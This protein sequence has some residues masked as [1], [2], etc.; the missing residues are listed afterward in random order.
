[1]PL[2]QRHFLVFALDCMK[3]LLWQCLLNHKGSRV[4]KRYE[5]SANGSGGGGEAGW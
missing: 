2:V 5:E 3:V 4:S 1:M